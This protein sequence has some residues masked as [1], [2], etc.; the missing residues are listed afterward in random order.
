MTENIHKVLGYLADWWT[1]LPNHWFYAAGVIIA[2]LSI[3]PVIVEG[4]KHLHLKWT[5]TE[6]TNHMIDFSLWVTAT[7]MG[8]ADFFIVNGSNTALLLPWMTGAI[9]TIKAFAPSVYTYSKAIHGWFTNRKNEK[10]EQRLQAVLAAADH[11][12]D[13]V[14]VSGE[15]SPS[16]GVAAAGRVDKPLQL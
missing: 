16:M 4:I 2:S 13:P 10:Q 12:I 7:L 5:A 1:G 8:L 15:A 11:M 3:T 9:A 6:M 14:T